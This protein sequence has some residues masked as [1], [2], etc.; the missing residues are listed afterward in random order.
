MACALERAG[1]NMERE[2]NYLAVGGFVLLVVVMG[3]LF[4]YW[5]SAS[6]DH[7]FYVRYEIYFD[8][9]VSGLSE[10]GPVRY[11][12]VDVGRVI[13]IRIDPRAANRVQVIADIDATTPISERTLAQLSLQGITGLLYIDLQQQRADDT[14]R[15]VL[16]AVPSQHYQVI[17]SAHSDFDLFLSSLPTL[18]ARLNELVDRSTQ[19]LSDKNIVGVERLVANL[20]RAAAQLPHTAGNIDSLVDELRSTINDAHQVIGDIHVATQTASVD[21]V[22]AVQKLRATSDNLER[23]TGSLDAFVAENRDLL[24]GFVRGGLPQIELLLRDS[25]AA[26]QEIRALSRSLRDNPSQL[27]YQPA[28]NGVVIPP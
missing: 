28:A 14:G 1:T 21:F 18:T 11:L 2:A 26:A 15:R 22:A 16:A 10:G 17:R 13:R 19:L 6:S 23:A 25:R 9:S 5:Y 8:G 24:S 7:R 4:V 20:D 3:V 27:I 12:G